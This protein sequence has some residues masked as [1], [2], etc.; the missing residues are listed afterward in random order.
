MELSFSTIKLYLT[1]PLKY[2]YVCVDGSHSGPTANSSLGHSIHAALE[3]YHGKKLTSFEDLVECYNNGWVNEGFADAQAALE[4]Y[5]K[6]LLILKNYHQSIIGT[7]TEILHVE[8]GFNVEFGKNRLRGEIDRID[9]HSDGSIEIIEYKTH[10]KLWGRQ[11]IEHDLQLPLYAIAVK[12]SLGL[13]AKILSYY[14][15]SHNRKIE[16]ETCIKDE[17]LEGVVN[18]TAKNIEEKKFE[19]N[20]KSCGF[21]EFKNKCQKGSR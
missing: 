1:C 11:E 13:P 5:D 19:A 7:K 8:Y 14:F 18:E 20:I 2:K 17:L 10:A 6:G 12:K 3:E 21:C 16:R 4:Y 9:K 15:L